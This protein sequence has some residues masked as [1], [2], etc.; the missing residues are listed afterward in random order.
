M[1]SFGSDYSSRGELS[2]HNG[3]AAHLVLIAVT[4]QTMSCRKSPGERKAKS[5]YLRALSVAVGLGFAPVGARN[6][7][8][9]MHHSAPLTATYSLETGRPQK[10]PVS[11]PPAS[12]PSF[13]LKQ[14]TETR[15][16]PQSES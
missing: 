6:L 15:N 12:C 2:A 13:P 16:G 10:H 11:L 4:T 7:I 3:L 14:V 5:P 8:F 9:K 1:L